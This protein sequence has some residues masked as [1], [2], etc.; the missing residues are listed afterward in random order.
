MV[1]EVPVCFRPGAKEFAD[2]CNVHDIPLLVFSAGLG[3]II[4]EI[5]RKAEMIVGT[6]HIVSNMMEFNEDGLIVNFKDPLIHILNKNEANIK[7][8]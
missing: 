2:N 8:F 5:M 7:G 6:L 1:R 4:Q 3:D